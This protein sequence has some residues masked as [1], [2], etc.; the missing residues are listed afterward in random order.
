M[1]SSLLC[2]LATTTTVVH[3]AV[4]A[5][6]ATTCNGVCL[7]NADYTPNEEYRAADEEKGTLAFSCKAAVHGSKFTDQAQCTG[8]V[9]DSNPPVTWSAFTNAHGTKCCGTCKFIH[10]D[11]VVCLPPPRSEAST[12]CENRRILICHS[13]VHTQD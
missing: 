11:S 9:P 6:E 4:C 1:K 12:D 7:D 10:D 3:G 13:T 8:P 2:L 5:A